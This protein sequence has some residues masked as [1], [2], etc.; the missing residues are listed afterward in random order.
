MPKQFYIR[1][2][3]TLLNH[4]HSSKYLRLV[5][6]IHHLQEEEEQ[7]QNDQ[8]RINNDDNDDDDV[9]FYNA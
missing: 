7:Q 4:I 6:D 1:T 5:I 3:N 9:H 2:N 8:E